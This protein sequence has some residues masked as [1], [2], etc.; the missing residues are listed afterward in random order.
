M[1]GKPTNVGCYALRRRSFLYAWRVHLYEALVG[2]PGWVQLGVT[3]KS[4]RSD[5]KPAIR[6]LTQSESAQA[7]RENFDYV[8]Q[9]IQ[10]E[11][12]PIQLQ[13]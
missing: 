5:V 3:L 7:V 4:G 8:V 6:A 10:N 13:T 9:L 1:S 2:W 12:G 11:K